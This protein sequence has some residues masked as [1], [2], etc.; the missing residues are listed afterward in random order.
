MLVLGG[1][2]VV[3]KSVT[4]ISC[5]WTWDLNPSCS[6]S[7]HRILRA[8]SLGHNFSVPFPWCTQL[9]FNTQGLKEP[10]T[11]HAAGMTQYGAYLLLS[12]GVEILH[13]PDKRLLAY[14]P[15][16]GNKYSS[17]SIPG[18]GMSFPLYPRDSYTCYAL[19]SQLPPP[20]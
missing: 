12:S 19:W 7:L 10:R 5:P 8:L 17:K 20:Q 6:G 11:W 15:W 3:V 2:V 13:P 18:R 9:G 16:R 4:P 1:G 14:F